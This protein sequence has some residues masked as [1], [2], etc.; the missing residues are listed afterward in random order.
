MCS[1]VPFT[2]NDIFPFYRGR[3]SNQEKTAGQI[4][5]LESMTGLPKKLKRAMIKKYLRRR[6]VIL[7]AIRA[8]DNHE[9][10]LKIAA[11]KKTTRPL[12]HVSVTTTRDCDV[13]VQNPPP[14]LPSSKVQVAG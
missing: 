9:R 4:K 13:S 11:G 2:P 12:Y 8:S 3:R 1:I 7:E 10:D 14:G 5:A 6:T